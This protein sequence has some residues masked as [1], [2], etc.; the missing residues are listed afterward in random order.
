MAFLATVGTFLFTALGAAIIFLFKKINNN[1]MPIICGFCAG[2]MLAASFFSLILPALEVLENNPYKLV[3][4]VI[5]FLF[6]T[7]GIL[8]FDFILENKIKNK[9]DSKEKQMILLMSAITLHNIPEGIAVGVA[10]GL[11]G[12]NNIYPYEAIILALAIGIQNIPEGMAISLP[13]KSNNKGNKLAFSLGALSGIVE[14]I[15]GIIG[16]ILAIYMNNILGFMLI[17]AS[18]A[19]IYVAV[20]E[21]IPEIIIENNNKYWFKKIGIISFIIG[22]TLMLTLD[23]FF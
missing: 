23:L 20:C 11:A 12:V 5:A 1:I 16:A 9:K 3:I 10:F 22:F 14:I 17:F 13:L 7:L 19:M 8:V 6:G 21:L 18:G 15:G 4:V 2:V